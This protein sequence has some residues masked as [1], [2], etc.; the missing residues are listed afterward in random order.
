MHYQLPMPARINETWMLPHIRDTYED[1]YGTIS[2]S[3]LLTQKNKVDH[4]IILVAN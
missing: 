2:R 3:C 4:A 1:K